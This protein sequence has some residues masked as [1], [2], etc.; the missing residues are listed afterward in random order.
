MYIYIYIY[1]IY[2]YIY[3]WLFVM[4]SQKHCFETDINISLYLMI[5]ASMKL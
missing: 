1:N 4:C 3:I 2:M 5:A